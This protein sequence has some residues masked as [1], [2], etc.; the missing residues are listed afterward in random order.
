MA[1]IGLESL[2][3]SR[4]PSRVSRQRALVPT[5]AFRLQSPSG[6]LCFTLPMSAQGSEARC[7]NRVG[8]LSSVKWLGLIAGDSS[9]QANGV[10]TGAPARAR[11][12]PLIHHRSGRGDQG[13]G[14]V[15]AQQVSAHGD[16]EHGVGNVDAALVVAHEPPTLTR[17]FPN[18][19]SD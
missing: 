17:E 10:E 9:S 5:A 18:R 4:P 2:D 6:R 12:E 7:R 19:L 16:E 1:L 15:S 3:A 13:S 14:D 8:R 11:V